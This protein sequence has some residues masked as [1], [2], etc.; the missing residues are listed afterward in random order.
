MVL[1]GLGGSSSGLLA[2]NAYIVLRRVYFDVILKKGMKLLMKIVILTAGTFGDVKPNVALAVGLKKAGHDVRIVTSMDGKDYITQHD[3]D[4]FSTSFSIKDLSS[5]NEAKRIMSAGDKTMNRF[6]DMKSYLNIF[7]EK[8]FQKGIE[9]CAGYD[10]IIPAGFGLHVGYHVGEALNI[11][12]IPVLYQPQ[13][14]TS[15]LPLCFFPPLHLGYPL[16]GL[17]NKFS[18]E[19]S[20]DFLTFALKGVVN[21]CRK[22]VGLSEIKHYKFHKTLREKHLPIIYGI[23]SLMLPKPSDY[24]KHLHFTGYFFLE[25]D[26]YYQPSQELEDFLKEGSKPVHIGFGSI[27][28]KNPDQLEYSILKALEKCKRRAVILTGWGGLKFDTKNDNIFVTQALPHDWLFPRM[29]ANVHHGGAG[30]VA[31]S[32]RAGVP[33]IT[34]PYTMDLP[35]F[36]RIAYEAGVAVKPIRPKNL[37][38]DTLAAAIIKATTDKRLIYRAKVLGAKMMQEDGVGNAVAVINRYLSKKNFRTDYFS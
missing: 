37:T 10:M 30:T 26:K 2:K 16:T 38:S 24:G 11:P 32:I 9:G 34:V 8:L 18:Y 7:I 25:E 20:D 4:Y 13:T 27:T 5:T 23:S 28:M 6:M 35:F 21:K 33:T 17:Y 22:S 12:V 31:T 14:M 19:L 3:I 15:D 36:S 29:A 1:K